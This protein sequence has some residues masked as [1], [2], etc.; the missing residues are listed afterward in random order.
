[1]IEKVKAEIGNVLMLML[2]FAFNPID[3]HP[4]MASKQ[5]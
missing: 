5:I 1:L 3:Y 4:M 2:L